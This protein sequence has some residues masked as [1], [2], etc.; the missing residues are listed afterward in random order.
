MTIERPTLPANDAECLAVATDAGIK[1][2]VY[3]WRD[4]PADAPALLWGHANGFSAGC[5]RPFLRRLAK[6]FRVFAYDARGH[7]AS[8]KPLGDLAELYDMLRFGEDLASIVAT[9]RARIGSDT[10]LH[11]ASHSLGGLAAVLL[12]GRLDMHPFASLTLFEPPIY[13]PE[14]HPAHEQAS[15]SQPLF[16]KWSARRQDRFADQAD[17]RAAAERISTFRTFAPDMFDAYV[18]AVVEPDGNGGLKLRC[19]REVESSVYANNYRAGVFE[20]AEGIATPAR[21]FSADPATV[22]SGHVWTPETMK[23]VAKRMANAEYR[24]FPNGQ[25]LMVQEFPDRAVREIRDHIASLGG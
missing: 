13:P 5:Y 7:G 10:P 16:V 11:Y 4:C 14:G 15:Q 21:I 2:A 25:H 12:E 18:E 20:A 9:V 19:P 6:H 24:P 3:A 1:V 8:D 22:D 17:V 23:S